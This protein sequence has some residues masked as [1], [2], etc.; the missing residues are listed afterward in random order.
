M[1]LIGNLKEQGE[2]A[3]TKAEARDAIKKAGMLLNDDELEQV[4]GGVKIREALEQIC[5]WCG[6]YNTELYGIDPKMRKVYFRCMEEWCT[7]EFTV[8]YD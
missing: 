1:K 2:N 3:G 8:Y 6:S 7:Y 4:A 5:P